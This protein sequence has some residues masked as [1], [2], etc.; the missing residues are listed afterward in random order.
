[1]PLARRPELARGV[2]RC[3]LAEVTRWL[4]REGVR[5]GEGGEPGTVTVMQRFGAALDLNLHFPVFLLDGVYVPD[6]D[7]APRFRRARRW[8]QADVDALIVRIAARY[9]AWLAR[10]GF[11]TDAERDDDDPDDVLPLLQSASVAGRSAVS[12]MFFRKLLFF[13]PTKLRP[14]LIDSELKSGH[15]PVGSGSTRKIELW[16]DI[17]FG[18][19]ESSMSH[20][21]GNPA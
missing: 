5:R 7:G 12:V 15:S 11:G 13:D 21:R 2:L 9:E 20:K 19:L 16:L 18:D 6:A 17:H 10:R 1:M 3:A 14:S 4:R 8:R